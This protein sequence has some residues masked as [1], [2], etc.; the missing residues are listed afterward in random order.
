MN[1]ITEVQSKRMK[2]YWLPDDMQLQIEI[3]NDDIIEILIFTFSKASL[4]ILKGSLDD[5]ENYIILAPLNNNDFSQKMII[6][7][8]LDGKV[9]LILSFWSE[10]HYVFQLDNIDILKES[11]CLSQWMTIPY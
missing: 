10:E 8:E 6:V 11:L 3:D 2:L 5:G 9:T 1:L 7:E 4:K